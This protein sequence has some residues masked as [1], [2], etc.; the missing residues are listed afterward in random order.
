MPSGSSYAAKRHAVDYD[1]PNKYT[2]VLRVYR[3]VG[4]IFDRDVSSSLCMV[5]VLVCVA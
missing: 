3:A 5:V 2:D 1:E 4:A